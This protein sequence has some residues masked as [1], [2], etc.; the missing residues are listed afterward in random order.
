MPQCSGQ[1]TR[2]AQASTVRPALSKPRFGFQANAPNG[3]PDVQ[4]RAYHQGLDQRNVGISVLV[5]AVAVATNS[6]RNRDGSSFTVLVTRTVN[7][8]KPGSDEVNRAYEEGWVGSQGYLKPDATRQRRAIAF[9]GDTVDAGGKKLTELFGADI[10][11]DITQSE[12]NTP[13]EGTATRLPA[14]PKGVTQRRQ[15]F[16]GDSK[17]PGIQGSRCA[18]TRPAIAWRF[19]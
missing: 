8:P 16:T 13:I 6:K 11:Q 19:S 5:R 17:N 14:P 10:P 4:H 18:P 9:L 15:T 2:G 7:T 1:V 12:A 3:F